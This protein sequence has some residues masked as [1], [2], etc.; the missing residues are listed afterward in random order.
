LNQELR[1]IR[2]LR[3]TPIA[4]LIAAAFALAPAEA[5]IASIL[6]VTNCADDGSPGTLRSTIAAA[7]ENDQVD[8]GQLTCAVITL[9][10]GQ[11]EIPQPDL[12]IE[13]K[14]H[15]GFQATTT[16]TTNF[17]GANPIPGRILHHTGGGS[18]SIVGPITIT[19]GA[20]LNSSS[21]ASGG[22]ISSNGNLSLNGAALSYCAAGGDSAI[23]GAVYATKSVS[24]TGTTI[25]SSG[26]FAST[27]AA[28]SAVASKGSVTVT[29]SRIYGNFSQP[30][31][32]GYG[33]VFADGAV[34]VSDSVI[35]GNQI[36]S[37]GSALGAGI[38]ALGGLTLSKSAVYGNS[39]SGTASGYTA[40]SGGGGIFALGIVSITNS[41][42]DHNSGDFG[43]GLYLYNS[44][45][46][47]TDSTVS[48]NS[49][50]SGGGGIISSGPLTLQNSTVAFNHAPIG[51]GVFIDTTHQSVAL[52]LQSA[53]LADNIATDNATGGDLLVGGSQFSPTSANSLVVASSVS[54]PGNPLLA[55]PRLQRLANN[56]GPTRTLALMHDSPAI[57]NG[58][59]GASLQNDQRGSGYPRVFGVGAD[60]GAYEW[61]GTADDRIFHSGYEPGCDE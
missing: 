21:T 46:T 55:C 5:A 13:H 29:S 37:G 33:A 36:T 3:S 34:S 17:S 8:V 44:S 59:N 16:I 50:S 12:T 1:H 60:I 39:A 38:A 57:D 27:T 40:R 11:I 58:N 7:G 61:Q 19:E 22:C 48:D 51:G 15:A 45:A 30:D 32:R 18:L 20:I 26:L 6:T 23:G 10:Q 2:G 28:G 47:V 4:T 25:T 41:T 56:G 24:L 43:G 54:L 9:T 14:Y 31:A 49:A 35:S 53:I 42:I 52:N